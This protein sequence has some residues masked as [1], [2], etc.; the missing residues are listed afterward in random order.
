MVRIIFHLLLQI[1]FLELDREGRNEFTQ[2]MEDRVTRP[3]WNHSGAYQVNVPY[4]V[5]QQKKLRISASIRLTF[6]LKANKYT[7]FVLCN[8][9]NPTYLCLLFPN[10]L[11]MSWYMTLLIIFSLLAHPSIFT[12][13]PI[14]I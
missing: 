11:C 13:R 9:S 8:G 6:F 10:H 1:H 3:P 2:R 14:F 5:N 4:R 12:T 7:V